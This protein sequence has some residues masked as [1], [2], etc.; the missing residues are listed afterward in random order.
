MHPAAK[1]E[2]NQAI[3]RSRGGRATKIY[4][5]T[6]SACRPVAF[7]LLAAKSQTVPPGNRCLSRFYRHP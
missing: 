7:M 3:G 5:L 6:D 1:G 2:N 4:A